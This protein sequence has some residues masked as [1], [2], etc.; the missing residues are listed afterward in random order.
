MDSLIHWV[1]AS[2]VLLIHCFPKQCVHTEGFFNGRSDGRGGSGYALWSRNCSCEM[3]MC[4]A[5]AH[6]SSTI[7]QEFHGGVLEVRNACRS[8]Q[9]PCRGPCAKTLMKPYQRTGPYDKLLWG[10]CWHRPRG[11]CRMS[12]WE[13][14][15][16]FLLTSSKRSLHDL[17]QV[18]ATLKDPCIKTLK[19][20]C[21]SGACVGVLLG[22]A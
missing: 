9:R 14:L 7:L 16:Q 13:D 5:T 18:L 2:L 22:C 8:W 15:V 20:L 21:I 1:V 4:I 12:L 3:S 11:P 10:S 19:M 6:V 17:V